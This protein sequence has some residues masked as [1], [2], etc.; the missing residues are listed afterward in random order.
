MYGRRF[1]EG[2]LPGLIKSLDDI[3]SVLLTTYSHIERLASLKEAEL[4]IKHKEIVL[5]QRELDLKE[6]VLLLKE[7]ELCL[8]NL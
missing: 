5:R 4:E 8:K 7:K 3:R 1:F 6:R 2:Q